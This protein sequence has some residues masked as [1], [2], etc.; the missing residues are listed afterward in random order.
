[1]SIAL[2]RITISTSALDARKFEIVTA[3]SLFCSNLL[4]YNRAD[5]IRGWKQII[6]P[7]LLYLLLRIPQ[8][9]TALGK[10][11]SRYQR[12]LTAKPPDI[13]LY[14][15]KVWLMY[16]KLRSITIKIDL[17]WIFGRKEKKPPN[18]TN[19]TEN[20]EIGLF[21]VLLWCSCLLRIKINEKYFS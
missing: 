4:L 18:G 11:C 8:N 17:F 13:S 7:L 10:R 15:T 19:C 21:L 2:S 1:M 5:T 16:R 14:F 20:H 6:D 3:L 9:Y 12:F